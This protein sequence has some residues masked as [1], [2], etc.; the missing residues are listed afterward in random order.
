MKLYIKASAVDA[1][2]VSQDV[3]IELLPTDKRR[4]GPA[5]SGVVDGYVRM[6]KFQFREKN[7]FDSF[8]NHRVGQRTAA[9]SS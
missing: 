5:G 4:S 8:A 2:G 3:L 9:N 6:G 7:G 1:N